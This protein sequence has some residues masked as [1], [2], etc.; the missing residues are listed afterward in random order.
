LLHYRVQRL[1]VRGMNYILLPKLNQAQME[2]L[3]RRLTGGSLPAGQRG[4]FTAKSG[5]DRIHVDAGGLCWSSSD[6]SDHVIPEIP[7]LLGCEKEAL[8]AIEVLRLYLHFDDGRG[9]GKVRMNTR[10]ESGWNW[11]TLRTSDECGLAPDERLIVL[12]FAEGSEGDVVTTTDYPGAGARP[13]KVGR[14][15]YFESSLNAAELSETLR[16]A[17]KRKPRNSYLPRDNILSAVDK[18]FLFHDSMKVLE[19]LGD[20]CSFKACWE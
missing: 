3:S 20:W 14:K 12:W 16:V 13:F 15:T 11:D 9:H 7:D 19:E 6:P 17:G 2:L 5:Q 18:A 4:S 10:I 1:E 8:G